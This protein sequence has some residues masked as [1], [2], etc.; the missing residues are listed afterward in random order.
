MPLTVRLPAVVMVVLALPC[1]VLGVT[2]AF[3][4]NVLRPIVGIGGAII[5]VAYGIFL[6]WVGQALW[7]GR[8]RGQGPAI[9][10]SLVHLPVAWSF[11]DGATAGWILAL[12]LGLGLVSIAVIVSLVL[13]VSMRALGRIPNRT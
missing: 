7:R 6:G 5:L 12:G 3:A 8:I 2:E 4:T 9:A 1:L 10:V 11:I 13:P